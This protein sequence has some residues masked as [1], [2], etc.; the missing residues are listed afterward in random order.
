MKKFLCLIFL[1]AGLLLTGCA[2]NGRQIMEKE[3]CFSCHRYKGYGADICPDLTEITKNRSDEFIIQQ[4]KDPGKNFPDS[5]MPS[6]NHLSDNE[7]KAI[8]DYLKTGK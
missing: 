6:Y 1:V 8:L 7:I 2:K 3:G 5:K 4:L